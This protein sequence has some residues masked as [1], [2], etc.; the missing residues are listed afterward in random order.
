MLTRYYWDMINSCVP[1]EAILDVLR[2]SGFVDVDRRVFGGF[3][4][5]YV[6]VKAGR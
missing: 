1:P 4:S 3:L 6:A 5:E 2:R